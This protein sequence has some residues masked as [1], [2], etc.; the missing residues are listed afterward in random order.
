MA[1]SL[2]IVFFLALLAAL[3]LVLELTFKSHWPLIVAALRGVPPESAS[4]PA[5]APPRP[6]RAAA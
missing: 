5:T 6:R 3:G 1:Q 2:S 4:R